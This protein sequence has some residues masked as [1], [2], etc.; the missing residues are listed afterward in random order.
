MKIQNKDVIT[1]RKKTGIPILKCREALEEAKGDFDEAFQVLKKESQKIAQKKA[2]R[3]ANEGIID[4]YIH[5]NNKIGVL[6][7]VSSETDFVA[8][9][10][11]FKKFAHD[12]AM[13]IAATN[14]KNIK[15]LLQSQFIKNLDIT[16]EDYLKNKIARI[17]ENIQIKRF[18][19]YELGE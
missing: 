5:S 4:A 15:E 7:E 17:G 11:E 2:S 16:I 8:K 9:N 13:Q 14:P 3:E 1:L 6:V 10:P 18:T 12:I 19:R